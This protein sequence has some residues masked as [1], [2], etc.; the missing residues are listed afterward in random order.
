[1]RLKMPA[2]RQRDVK[3]IFHESLRRD[4]GEARENYLTSACSG[5]DE[6]RTEVQSLLTSLEDAKTFLEI[7]ITAES[8][9]E[10]GTTSLAPGRVISHYRIDSLLGCGGMGEVYLATDNVLKRS[11]AMKIVPDSL[12]ADKARVRRF[13]RE[14]QAIA[15]LNHPN[16]MTIYEFVKVRRKNFIV[17]EFIR[18]ETVRKRLARGPMQI[19]EVLDIA[20]QTAA[21]LQAAHSARIIHRDIKPENI[22]VRDDGYVKVLDFGLAKLTGATAEQRTPELS[23]TSQPGL[24]L[25]TSNY[26]SPEQARGKDVDHRTDLFSLGV[27]VYEMLTGTQPFKGE[28]AVDVVAEIIQSDPPPVEK[29]DGKIPKKL[30]RLIKRLLEKDPKDRYPDAAELKR[31]LVEVREE[32]KEDEL[33]WW[34]SDEREIDIYEMPTNELPVVGRLVPPNSRYFVILLIILLLLTIFLAYSGLR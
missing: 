16:I 6:L 31:D 13:E 3:E 12:S 23:M 30:S 25:G 26:V 4:A 11:V 34:R 7:P 9:L 19:G 24:I 5:N 15:E 18:G 33:A 20:I 27:V 28:T 21:A 29:L 22:M 14:A 2:V 1:M 17:S 32:I 10:I 8:D